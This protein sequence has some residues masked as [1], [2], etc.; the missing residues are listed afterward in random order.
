MRPEPPLIKLHPA[1]VRKVN[2]VAAG[3]GKLLEVAV[4]QLHPL[5][6][7]LCGNG[8]PI[9]AAATNNQLGLE[10]FGLQ[11]EPLEPLVAEVLSLRLVR[12]G[13]VQAFKEKRVGVSHPTARFRGEPVQPLK[14]PDGQLQPVVIEH[15]R[16]VRLLVAGFLPNPL[17]TVPLPEAIV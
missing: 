2:K 9:D 5:L 8:E 13:S 16:L 7:P 3:S 4:S 11:E 1:G 10:S 6:L 17:V 15:L 14:P 12:P